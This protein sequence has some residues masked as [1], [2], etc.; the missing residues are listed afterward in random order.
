[1]SLRLHWRLTRPCLHPLSRTLGRRL[2][3][4]LGGRGPNYLAQALS[5]LARAV[6]AHRRL[7]KLAPEQFDYAV[8]AR[9]A[10]ERE[11]EERRLAEWAVVIARVYGT[12]EEN[13]VEEMRRPRN[14]SRC[15][16]GAETVQFPGGTRRR[17]GAVER[18]QAEWEL[19]LGVGRE[20]LDRHH[21]HQP[22]RW[23]RLGTVARLI[24][25]AGLLGRLSVGCVLP[26]RSLHSH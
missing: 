16:N 9:L 22:H 25:L 3:R 7:I 10:R 11:E 6:R 24:D 13:A 2:N 15:G 17:A 23:L 26:G 4:P 1:M 19:W 18:W 20:A 12:S 14:H 5:A 21:R 8:V